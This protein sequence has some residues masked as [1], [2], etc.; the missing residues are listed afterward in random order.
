MVVAVCCCLIE[1]NDDD[2]DDD[3]KSLFWPLRVWTSA[4]CGSD[5]KNHEF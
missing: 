4:L 2:D 3:V 1:F 5:W